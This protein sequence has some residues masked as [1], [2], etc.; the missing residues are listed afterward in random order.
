MTFSALILS[1]MQRREQKDFRS[2]V[3]SLVSSPST[4]N[5]GLEHNF[6]F[7]TALFSI[8]FRV[9]VYELAPKMLFFSLEVELSALV[10]HRHIGNRENR[11]TDGKFPVEVE[12]FEL[13]QVGSIAGNF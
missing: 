13:N 3:H 7:V 1:S 5:R 11:K 6:E 4:S 12:L 9:V 10:T 8:S 2:F